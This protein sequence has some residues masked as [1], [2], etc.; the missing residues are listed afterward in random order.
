MNTNFSKSKVLQQRAL[1]LEFRQDI[2]LPIS[3]GHL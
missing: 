3:D 2:F 1:K